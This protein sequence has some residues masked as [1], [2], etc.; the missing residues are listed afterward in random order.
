M[1]EVEGVVAEIRFRNEENYYTVFNL[2]TED[3]NITVVGKVLSISVGDSMT[4]TG[5]LVYHDQY[6]EQIALYTYKKMMPRT[7]VQ[8]EKYLAS[9]I[10][11]FI[12]KKTAKKIVDLYGKDSLDIIT[13]DPNSLRAIKGLGQ[14]RIKKI[15]EVLKRE[16]ESREVLIY[17]QSLGLGNKISMLI[18]KTYKEEAIDV[19]KKNPYVLIEDIKGIGFNIADDIALRNKVERTDLFRISAGL[20]YY[21]DHQANSNGNCYVEKDRLLTDVSK[22]LKIDQTYIESALT[23]AQITGRIKMEFIDGKMLVYS[24]KIYDKEQNIVSNIIRLL[25]S[26]EEPISNI[27]KMLETNEGFSYSQRQKEAIVEAIQKKMLIIT[28]GPGT[29]KT[30]IIKGIIDLLQKLSMTFTLCAPTGRAAKRME[31]S[32]G[33]MASTIHRLLGFKSLDSEDKFLEFD[34]DKPLPYDVVIVDEVSMID[35][36]LMSDL[37]D[38]IDNQTRL[39]LVGDVD[40][41]PSVGPGNVLKD[42]IDSDLIKTIRLDTIFRQ[43]ETSNIVK[44][45]HL[46]NKGLMPILNEFGKDFFFISCQNEAQSLETIV[47]LVANRLPKHYK[48]DSFKDIQVLSAMKRGLCGVDN[49]N[50]RLQD[51]L[52]PKEFNKEEVEFAKQVFRE[53]DRVMQTKNNYDLDMEDEFGNKQKGVYNGDMGIVRNSFSKDGAMEVIIDDKKVAYDYKDLSELSLSYAITIH[54]SQGSEFPVVVIPMVSGPYMLLSRNILYTAITRAK[55]LVVLVGSERVMKSMIEN[56][57]RQ[58][59]NSSLAY[60]LKVKYS[61]FES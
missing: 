21:L 5:N 20:Q 59:R 45:A 28:G 43:E 30:T 27:E 61:F 3:G 42:L 54:K 24:R 22:L 4:V 25:L 47:D 12:G 32:T 60:F 26:Q 11:P 41:L 36:Y 18:Y 35:I 38:A 29:G 10:I 37:L 44:N 51:K 8:I 46:I 16:K 14:K 55:K 53:G 57:F 39:I 9:G 7:V 13:E 19:I 50:L 40:Q 1:I 17:L 23:H 58:N 31:E 49:L 2:D 15:S 56:N 48:L 34:K 52:N 33:Q 6:G